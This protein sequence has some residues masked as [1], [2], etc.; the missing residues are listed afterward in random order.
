MHTPLTSK[1]S[2]LSSTDHRSWMWYGTT[3]HRDDSKSVAL[4]EYNGVKIFMVKHIK[5]T[6]IIQ[7]VFI[8]LQAINWMIH[9][10]QTTAHEPDMLR[11]SSKMILNLWHWLN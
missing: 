4:C 2:D 10:E 3:S 1:L 9:L 5:Q 11:L 8:H 7:F 6:F